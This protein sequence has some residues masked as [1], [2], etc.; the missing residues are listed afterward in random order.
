MGNISIFCKT[1]N[2]KLLRN[3]LDA[4]GKQRY[5]CPQ[6]GTSCF[7]YRDTTSTD[8]FNLFRYYVLEGLTYRQLQVISGYSISTLQ[9]AFQGYL[10]T[11]QKDVIHPAQTTK[12]IVLLLD[13]LW[14]GRSFVVMAYR[15]S[16]SL[17]IIRIS[18]GVKELKSIIKKDL[19]HIS[20]EGY[21]VSG[22]VSDG[23]KPILGALQYVYPSTPHQVCLAHMHRSLISSIGKYPH[24]YCVQLLKHLSDMVW[25][26]QT[27]EQQYAWYTLVTFWQERY[28][29]YVNARRMDTEG[30]WWYI[31]KGVRKALRTMES[32]Y[33]NSFTFIDYSCLPRTTNQIEAQFGHLGR[34]FLAHRGLRNTRWESFLKWFVFFYNEK[35]DKR[36]KNGS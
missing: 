36:E 18:T 33:E 3:G 24:E 31:H 22:I 6:C 29:E 19:L 28:H 21:S 14:F 23:G 9:T 2:T 15:S 16:Q 1:C 11:V 35:I 26:V 20:A 5:R 34:R 17:K 12:P 25:W 7:R 10:D 13:G 8:L 30:I 32:I 4:R 27:K